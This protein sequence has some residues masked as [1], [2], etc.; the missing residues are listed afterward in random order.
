MIN[1]QKH[2]QDKWKTDV[3]NYKYRNILNNKQQRIIDN[4]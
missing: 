1:L 3:S 4:F 2:V